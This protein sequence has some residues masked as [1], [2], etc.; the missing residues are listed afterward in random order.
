MI[1]LQKIT[2]E[3]EGIDKIT[4]QE[5]TA[6]QY[7]EHL[8]QHLFFADSHGIICATQGEYPIACTKEQLTMLIN[9]LE[10]KRGSLER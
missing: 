3:I 5:M 8:E 1:Q 10:T 6:N 7:T 2:L 9:Y 4:M